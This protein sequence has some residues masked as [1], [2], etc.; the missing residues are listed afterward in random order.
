MTTRLK[1]HPW[2][3]VSW[4]TLFWVAIA[5]CLQ[6][7]QV[8]SNPFLKFTYLIPLSIFKLYQVP[9]TNS[10]FEV[11]VFKIVETLSRESS[12]LPEMLSVFSSQIQMLAGSSGRLHPPFRS[13]CI[14]DCCNALQRLFWVASVKRQNQFYVQNCS[15]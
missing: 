2:N 10:I 12:G 7:L 5:K 1:S 8:N 4:I 3:L 11:H 15:I 14:Q 6:A 13:S 9:R